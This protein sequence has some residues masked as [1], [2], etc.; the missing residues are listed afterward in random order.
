MS[1]GIKGP[2]LLVTA[3]F[4]VLTS[5]RGELN[6]EPLVGVA[7][8]RRFDCGVCGKEERSRGVR[9]MPFIA[10]CEFGVLRERLQIVVSAKNDCFAVCFCAR[11][12]E[13]RT[14]I[15]KGSIGFGKRK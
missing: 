7:S 11:C 15:E 2:S 5:G 6:F 12:Y 4:N 3:V 10:Y 13:V 9:G 8:G 1:S 14:L